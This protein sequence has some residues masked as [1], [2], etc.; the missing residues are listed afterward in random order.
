VH[1]DLIVFGSGFAAYEVARVAIERGESVLVIERGG[2]DLQSADPALSHVPVLG[3]PVR[4]GG[5]DFG[6]EVPPAFDG[7]PRYI[8]LGGTS[9]LWSGKW[10]RLDRV[11]FERSYEGRRWPIGFDDLAPWYDRVAADYGWPDWA[12][13]PG[14]APA[15]ARATAHGLRLIEI[16]EEV[17]PVR[18]REKWRALAEHGPL[19]LEC[20]ARLE[21]ATFTPDD[22]IDAI[23]FLDG[24]GQ[25]REVSA[26]AIVVAA[27][28]IESIHVSHAL[29]SFM[30]S[31]AVL[32]DRYVGFADHPKAF[33]GRIEPRDRQFVDYLR[34]AHAARRRLIA[35][36]LPEQEL[37]SRRLGN[38]TVFVTADE[39]P[40]APGSL[41]VLLSLEQ[42]PETDNFIATRPDPAVHW[43]VST[44]TR[45]DAH[46]FLSAFA[47]RLSDLVGPMTVDAAVPLRGASHHAAALPMGQAG[48]APLDEH[49]RFHD[50]AN[51]YCVSS[52]VFPIAGS[53]NPTMTILALARRLADRL[54]ALDLLDA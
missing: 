35:F 27:G 29:R 47:S 43:R 12:G 48:L 26:N 16:Y 18:L 9:E 45:E 28:G 7:V 34:D 40:G 36:G 8:G 6:V 50:V 32:P 38:H 51:L 25:A 1:F 31:K 41:R 44:A 14:F 17:P 13:D 21:S 15:N 37:L 42:F 33:I 24:Q 52:A 53:A 2:D 5:F 54:G 20:R 11:D 22:R 49:C 19:D 46:H 10:R 4:S 23:R 30:A 3:E 39:P